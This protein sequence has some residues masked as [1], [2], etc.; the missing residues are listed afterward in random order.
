M[1]EYVRRVVRCAVTGR[2][3]DQYPDQQTGFV[4]RTARQLAPSRLD[5]IPD[6][7]P[8]IPERIGTA[9][10]SKHS[11]TVFVRETVRFA[12]KYLV[13]SC[14][15]DDPRLFPRSGIGAEL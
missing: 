10:L 5:S 14:S 11:S 9:L 4:D 12:S 1:A 7:E 15:C 3:C 6:S 2:D 8:S 13:W